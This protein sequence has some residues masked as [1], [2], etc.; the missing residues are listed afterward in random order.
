MRVMNTYHLGIADIDKV[1][2]SF[3]AVLVAKDNGVFKVYTGVVKL[4]EDVSSDEYTAARQTAAQAIMYR[5]SPER[6]DRAKTYFPML[7]EEKYG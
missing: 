3:L 4:P 1:G 7:D 5:G 6:F 2:V